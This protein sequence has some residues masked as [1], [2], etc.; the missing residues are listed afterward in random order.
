MLWTHEQDTILRELWT[1][2]VAATEIN[3]QL[4]RPEDYDISKRRRQLGLPPRHTRFISGRRVTRR[5]KPRPEPTTTAAER[6]PT[7][8]IITFM[9]ESPRLEMEFRH[10]LAEVRAE[11]GRQWNELLGVTR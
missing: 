5:L 10:L 8:S 7:R 1:A 4:G 11:R 9:P 3:R 2:G 6:M